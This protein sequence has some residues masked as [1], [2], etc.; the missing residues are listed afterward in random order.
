MNTPA[1]ID[2]LSL[3]RFLLDPSLFS[4]DET[5]EIE[6]H[7]VT[8]THCNGRLEDMRSFHQELRDMIGKTDSNHATLLAERICSNIEFMRI[9]S[10]IELHSVLP[11]A[12]IHQRRPSILSL[13]AF[14]GDSCSTTHRSTTLRS[15]DGEIILRMR[16]GGPEGEWCMQ[17]HADDAKLYAHVL[18]F[19]SPLGIPIIT[20]ADG[21]ATFTAD[22]SLS[23]Q[24]VDALLHPA[25]LVSDVPPFLPLFDET[26]SARV[27]ID[28]W[29]FE[30][31]SSDVQIVRLRVSRVHGTAYTLP[32]CAVPA[33]LVLIRRGEADVRELEDD[34][35]DLDPSVLS[36]TDRIIL[37]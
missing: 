7:L 34:K 26:S 23:L 29:A 10:P 13:A 14:D 30:R 22:P 3:E 11:A 25:L 12:I 32:H 8:C 35:I 17:V 27:E 18:V 36:D 37:Y 9:T 33:R 31:L 16:S 28:D 2:P 19:L 20:D 1:H 4:A 24:D 5:A 15:A 21:E 6:A